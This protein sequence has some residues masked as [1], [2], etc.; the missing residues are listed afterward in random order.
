M[1]RPS[2]RER[3]NYL[4][5]G[6]AAF[7][8]AILVAAAMVLRGTGSFDRTDDVYVEVP[9]AV[10]IVNAGAP[11]RYLGVEVG[12]ISSIEAGTT[13]S[14]V[15]LAI[16]AK[17]SPT[18]PA[19]VLARVVPRTFF[20]DIY[21]ELVSDGDATPGGDRAATA[22]ADIDTIPVDTGP[23]AVAMYDVF[24]RM[25]SVLEEM[26]PQAM[27]TALDALARA[28]DGN[29]ETIGRT[30]DRLASTTDQLT[31]ALEEFISA[32]PQ[33]VTV[34]ESLDAA[35][36]D[37]VGMLSS[38]TEVSRAIV[39]HRGNLTETLSAATLLASSVDGFAT[40]RRDTLIT[41]TDSLGTI[42]A[43]TGANP[44][45]LYATLANAETFGAA[46]AR[47]FSSGRFDIT[48][49]PTFAGP[50][51]YTAADCP[52]Y[53]SISGANCNSPGNGTYSAPKPVIDAAAEA[54]PLQLIEQ[55]LRGEGDTAA[56]NPDA[57]ENTGPHAAVTALLAPLF[58]GSEVK[59][60]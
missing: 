31:P 55:Q 44:D 5:R 29:G 37:I 11:V 24:T 39:E 4:I 12:E 20:G 22:L 51:P 54:G 45:G 56:E 32:T 13:E 2:S 53:G 10:G 34:M 60:P 19:D 35:T 41:V 14:R 26:E 16:D 6:I 47:V 3:L 9:A 17:T 59:I 57:P 52:T 50:L 43:T 21:V 28:L 7:G 36:P 49:V 18:I 46:G 23:D 30:I 40:P 8:V 58:R 15:R 33:F 38:A 42:L 25:S 48:A 1:D 27:A